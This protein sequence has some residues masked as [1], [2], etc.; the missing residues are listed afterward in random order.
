MGESALVPIDA[1]QDGNLASSIH[2]LAGD[3]ESGPFD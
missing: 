1:A 2:M 3:D